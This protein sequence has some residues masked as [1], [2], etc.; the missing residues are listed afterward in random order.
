MQR[1]VA[2]IPCPLCEKP[3]RFA[4]ATTDK[5]DLI[6]SIARAAIRSSTFFRSVDYDDFSEENQPPQ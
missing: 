2:P 1:N 4:I 6:A 3:V 5:L